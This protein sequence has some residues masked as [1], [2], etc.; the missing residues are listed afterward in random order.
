MAL[1]AIGP[2]LALSI[3]VFGGVPSRT[4][5]S[6]ARE[7]GYG[8]VGLPAWRRDFAPLEI[9]SSGARDLSSY[10][11][12]NGLAVSVLSAGSKGRF[13]VSAAV[14]EDVFAVRGMLEL[15][16]K[17]GAGAVTARV[18]EVGST[19]SAPATN[20]REALSALALVADGVGVPLAL[21]PQPRDA[22]S[23]DSILAEFADAPVGL[24][25]DPAETLFA[26]A[27]PVDRASSAVKIVAVRGTDASAEEANLAPGE[28]RVPWRDLLAALGGRDYYGYITVEFARRGDS[29]SR[30][31]A[32]LNVLRQFAVS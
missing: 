28:G 1:G 19:D 26:G 7:C 20:L 32:A 9:G 31:R 12:R 25:F 29:T 18:G 3:E 11:A 5:I 17:L 8:A 4:A 6:L 24:A 27:D 2:S 23:V 14:E 13:T 16:G 21:A 10:L 15:A 22:A 30:A